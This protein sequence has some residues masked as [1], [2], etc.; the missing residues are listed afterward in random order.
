[1]KSFIYKVAHEENW[2]RG[3]AMM[4][5]KNEKKNAGADTKRGQATFKGLVYISPLKISHFS[6]N[7]PP[8][9]AL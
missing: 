4:Q 3:K 9:K 5:K 8:Q 1:M 6:P 2:V 7:I